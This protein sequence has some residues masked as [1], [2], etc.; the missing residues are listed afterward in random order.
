MESP[1]WDIFNAGIHWL[2]FFGALTD[3]PVEMVLTAADTSERTF[4]D[5][6]QVETEAITMARTTNGVRVLLNTGDHLPVSSPETV[7]L[8]PHHRITRIH[9]MSGIRIVLHGDH[10]GAHAHRR[11]RRAVCGERPSAPPRASRP[12]D[13]SGKRSRG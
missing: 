4:R 11:E 5:G 10:P 7:C 9:R 8:M 12:P 2:Q 13:H 6:M 3:S 1:R